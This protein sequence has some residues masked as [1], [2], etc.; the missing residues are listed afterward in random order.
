MP[1][2]AVSKCAGTSGSTDAGVKSRSKASAYVN[3]L[4]AEPGWR[5]DTTPSMAPPWSASR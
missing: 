1:S 2:N 4:S 5:G 3:G